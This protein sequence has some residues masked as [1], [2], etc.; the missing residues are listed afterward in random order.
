MFYGE[1]GLLCSR[2]RS[3]QNLKMSVNVCPDGIFWN[4]EPFTTKLGMLMQHYEPNCLSER[5][6]CCLQGQGHRYGSII[7]ICLFNILSEL[8]ILLQLNLVLW[9][10]IIRVIVLRKEWIALLWSRSRSQKKFRIPVNV[11][12]DDISSAAD[13]L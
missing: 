12:L 1:V 6:V 7:K 13:L 10:I 4:A 11:H 9:F 2:S 8:L 5:L 3:E